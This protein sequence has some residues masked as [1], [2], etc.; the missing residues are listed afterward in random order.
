MD[1]SG[2]MGLTEGDAYAVLDVEFP[3]NT[4]VDLFLEVDSVTP[5][6]DAPSE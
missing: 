6:E 1:G 3:V 2:P 4:T 5:V